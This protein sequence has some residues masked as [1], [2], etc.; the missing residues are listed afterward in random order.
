MFCQAFGAWIVGAG[1]SQTFLVAGMEGQGCI[2]LETWL[3]M[4]VGWGFPFTC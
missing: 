4:D 1:P 2:S 3:W